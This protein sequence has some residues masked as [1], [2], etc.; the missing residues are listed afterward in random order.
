MQILIAQK[1]SKKSTR[2]TSD[3]RIIPSAISV[4]SDCHVDDTKLVF[5][6]P[7]QELNA[8]LGQMVR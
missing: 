5:S 2:C 3:L 4:P 1:D 6:I 7:K 8:E